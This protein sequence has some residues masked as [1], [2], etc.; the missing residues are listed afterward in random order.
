MSN[1]QAL[2]IDPAGIYPQILG[3]ANCWGPERDARTYQGTDPVVAHPPCQLWTNMAAVNFKRYPKEKNRPG[4]DQGCFL[5]ALTMLVR[6]GGVL[7]HPAGSKAFAAHG[8]PKPQRGSWQKHTTL[9]NGLT[10]WLTEVSQCA[11]GHR[12]R[13]RTWLIYCGWSP[14]RALDWSE[15]PYTHQI[16]HDSTQKR[17]KPSLGKKEACASPRAFALTLIGLA[18]W[19]RHV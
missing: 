19:C 4:N 18:Q 15:P 16:G 12:A 9:P 3:P 5:R 1:V 11:Y 14:P 2:F 8:L 7:E 6:N 17:P 13:K 10:V